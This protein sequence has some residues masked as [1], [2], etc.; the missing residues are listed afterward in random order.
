MLITLTLS[1][2]NDPLEIAD[3]VMRQVAGVPWLVENRNSLA[4]GIV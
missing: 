2:L 3:A 1:S 4:I